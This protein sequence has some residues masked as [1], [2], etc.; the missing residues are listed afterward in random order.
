MHTDYPALVGCAITEVSRVRYVHYSVHN[1]Q[2]T[3]ILLA[4]G[5]KSQ[6]GIIHIHGPTDIGSAGIYIQR[7]NEM[8]FCLAIDQCVEEERSRG[9]IDN[10]CAN[11]ANRAFVAAGKA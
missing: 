11:D 9:E 8:L 7:I 6:S 4:Q 5:R 2:R 1:G 10:R 3:S